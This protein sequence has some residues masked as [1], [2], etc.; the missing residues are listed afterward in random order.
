MPLFR[1]SELGQS[2]HQPG[3]FA[4]LYKNV[5]YLFVVGFPHRISYIFSAL[6]TLLHCS[7]NTGDKPLSVFAFWNIRSNSLR[8]ETTSS[9]FT[10]RHSLQDSFA[11]HDID[12]T[13]YYY[14]LLQNSNLT[15]NSFTLN[16]K[17]TFMMHVMES[18]FQTHLSRRQW[19][20]T[21]EINW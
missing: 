20:C 8:R 4:K 18:V 14:Y 9:L 2:S 15:R 7:Q 12:N 3:S 10:H 13:R 1:F 6:S 11:E 5:F 16:Y 21:V 19:K 17:H